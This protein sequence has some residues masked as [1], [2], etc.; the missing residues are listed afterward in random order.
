MIKELVNFPKKCPLPN[1]YKVE[2]WEFDNSYRWVVDENNYSKVSF[3]NKW[4][5]HKH[6]WSTYNKNKTIN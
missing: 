4:Q 3:P 1:G 2:W 6:A 5:T